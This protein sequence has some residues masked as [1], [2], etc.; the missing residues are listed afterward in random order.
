M[1]DENTEMIYTLSDWQIGSLK[2]YFNHM[3]APEPYNIIIHNIGIT[4][5][6]NLIIQY[7]KFK[8]MNRDFIPREPN[9]N[10]EDISKIEFK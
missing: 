2:G 7:E 9:K 1:R 4:S 6:G 5:K 10:I 3:Y 8:T